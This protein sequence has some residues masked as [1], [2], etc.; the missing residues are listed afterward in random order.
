VREE[1]AAA[2]PLACSSAPSGTV[3]P[4]VAPTPPGWEPPTEVGAGWGPAAIA[5]PWAPPYAW[6]PMYAPR[7]TP[8][9]AIAALVLGIVGITT[10]YWIGWLP[11]GIA[12]YLGTKA[13]RRIDADPTGYDGRGIAVAGQITG[14][15]SLAIGIVATLVFGAFILIAILSEPSS[16]TY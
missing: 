7:Q 8:G 1:L 5:P 13:K 14:A 4:V 3:D 12:L 9:E 15:V 10:C 6:Q 11:G 2:A 16:S